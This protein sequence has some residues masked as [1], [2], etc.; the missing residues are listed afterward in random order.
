MVTGVSPNSL[1]EAISLSLASQSPGLLILASRTRSKL[2]SIVSQ[3]HSKYPNVLVTTVLL[4]LAAQIS[5]R[6]AAA[7]IK[8]LIGEGHI[9][10]LFNNAGINVS[11]R[12]LTAE[13][14]ELQ[15]GTNHLGPFLFTNLLMPLLL[16]KG[17]GKEEGRVVMTSSEAHRISPVRFSD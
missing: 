1:G 14:I 9:D 7:E 4:D 11:E 3:I 10:V 13:G 12:R 8:N 16:G 6:S 2:D 5:S 17:M 15:F